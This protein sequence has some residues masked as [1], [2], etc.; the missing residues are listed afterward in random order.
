M[1]HRK[2][3]SRRSWGSAALAIEPLEERQL[4]AVTPGTWTTVNATIPDPV[5]KDPL[6]CCPMAP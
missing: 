5:V 6:S 2:P 4:L 3:A 1:R